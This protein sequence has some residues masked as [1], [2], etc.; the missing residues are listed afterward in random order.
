MFCQLKVLINGV[1]AKEER[2]ESEREKNPCVLKVDVKSISFVAMETVRNRN[3][4]IKVY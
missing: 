3:V 4:Y 2:K 1:C